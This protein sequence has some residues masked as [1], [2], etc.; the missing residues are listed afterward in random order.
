MAASLAIGAIVYRLFLGGSSFVPLYVHSG[1]VLTVGVSPDHSM[2]ASG[3]VDGAIRVFS[4]ERMAERRSIQHSGTCSKVAFSPDGDVLAF[5]SSD[6]TNRELSILNLD[7][8]QK[9]V[10]DFSGHFTY[11]FAFVGLREVALG[12]DNEIRVINLDT[13]RVSFLSTDCNGIYDVAC[14]NDGKLLAALTGC[15]HLFVWELQNNRLLL[16]HLAKGLPP[17]GILFTTDT[18]IITF[19]NHG[20]IRVSP[21]GA[22]TELGTVGSNL[23]I[24]LSGASIVEGKKITYSLPKPVDPVNGWIWGSRIMLFD[25]PS[26]KSTIAF[27]LRNE[28]ISDYV[29]L[30]DNRVIAGTYN[31]RVIIG[32]LNH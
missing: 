15:D 26:K 21:N 23:G 20:I 18:N 2:L 30:P 4:L 32:K 3:G 27:T 12:V 13:G 28:A 31:G 11:S 17:K 5:L 16:K 25:E 8:G 14:S 1:P 7:T 24:E 29:V 10:F 22:V 9:K 6:E 19:S